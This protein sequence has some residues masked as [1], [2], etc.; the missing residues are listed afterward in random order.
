MLCTQSLAIVLHEVAL[1]AIVAKAVDSFA[2]AMPLSLS[3][4]DIAEP[5]ALVPHRHLARAIF[6]DLDMKWIF[7]RLYDVIA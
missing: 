5:N 4:D 7:T 3:A 1:A 2:L 6:N